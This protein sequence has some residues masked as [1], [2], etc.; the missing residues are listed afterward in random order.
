MKKDTQQLLPLPYFQVRKSGFDNPEIVNSQGDFS[1]KSFFMVVSVLT[2]LIPINVFAKSAFYIDFKPGIYS[3]HSSDPDGFDTGFNG[4][5]IHYNITPKIFVGVEG[6]H[7]VT[8][9]PKGNL[10]FDI[11]EAKFKMD[12]II[13]NGV[14]S[15][16]F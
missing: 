12:G 15:I 13:V 4:T 5:R 3:T 10:A 2:F 14:I 6:K 9:K 7:L 1:L 8:D 11:P 16:R